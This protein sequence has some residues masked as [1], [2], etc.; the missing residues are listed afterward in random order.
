[1]AGRKIRNIEGERFGRWMVVALA[2]MENKR[3]IYQCRCECGTEKLIRGSSLTTG[4]SKS[5][6]CYQTEIRYTHRKSKT[7]SHNSW[8]NML[9]RCFNEN[10]H[11]Y[12]RYGGR[13]ISVCKRWLKFENFF[14]DMGERPPGTSLHRKDNDK[15]YFPSNCCWTNHI[16]QM[17]HTEQN[18]LIT[19]RGVTKTAIEWSE[20]LEI[21]PYAIY[22]RSRRG[23]SVE[24][25]LSPCHLRYGH[26]IYNTK[27]TLAG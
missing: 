10:C 17:R 11:Y 9:Q 8:L 15:G 14:A 5:C 2:H 18:N 24:E 20:L 22:G 19:Y 4:N 27:R 6:G 26:R 3:A 21:P 1:M 25:I 13:G 16:Q 12:H 23:C 7:P